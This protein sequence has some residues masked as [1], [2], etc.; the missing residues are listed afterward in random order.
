MDVQ[1]G[2]IMRAIPSMRPAEEATGRQSRKGVRRSE[3]FSAMIVNSSAPFLN[4]DP[5][6]AKEKL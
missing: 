5:R 6:E 3:L 1:F 2:P 4:P